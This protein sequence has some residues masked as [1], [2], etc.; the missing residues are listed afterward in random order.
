MVRRR[1]RAKVTAYDIAN[2]TQPSTRYLKEINK[3]LKSPALRVRWAVCRPG[4]T[5]WEMENE[6]LAVSGVASNV[7][8]TDFHTWRIK[9]YQHRY[10]FRNCS[11][12]PMY[13]SIYECVFR[14]DQCSDSTSTF[15]A[16]TEAQAY[17]MQYLVNGWDVSTQAAHVDTSGTGTVV[18]Y[19]NGAGHCDSTMLTLNPFKSQDF[20]ERFKI[21]KTISGKLEVGQSFH[22]TMR[23]N[24]K[25]WNRSDYYSLVNDASGKSLVPYAYGGVTKFLLLGLRGELGVS[26]DDQNDCGWMSTIMATE[27]KKTARLLRLTNFRN[28][29]AIVD[30][31]DTDAVLEGPAEDVQ[32]ADE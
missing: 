4:M 29:N 8:I 16:Q 27:V 23:C 22:Y 11:I 7:N 12:Q 30:S 31:H 18:E 20:V 13:L 25:D 9:N 5:A 1:K 14:N 28:N 2:V 24:K 15:G 3:V 17:C 21:V 32:A 6:L 10:H 19:N 26:V